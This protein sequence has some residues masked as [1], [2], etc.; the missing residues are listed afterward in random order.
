MNRRW[1]RYFINKVSN[2]LSNETQEKVSDLV[3]ERL[4]IQAQKWKAWY[5]FWGKAVPWIVAGFVII[6]VSC[7]SNSILFKL[8]Q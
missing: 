5:A 1:D 4:R 8:V 6:S 3:M 2:E 7:C